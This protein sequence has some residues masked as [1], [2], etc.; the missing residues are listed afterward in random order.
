MTLPVSSQMAGRPRT[1]SGV[2]ISRSPARSVSACS[3]AGASTTRRISSALAAFARATGRAR[4]DVR[5]AIECGEQ[6]VIV[7]REHAERSGAVARVDEL[8]AISGTSVAGKPHDRRSARRRPTARS[9]SRSRRNERDD[10]RSRRRVPRHRAC[11][12][13]FWTAGPGSMPAVRSFGPAMSMQ[14][15]QGRPVSADARLRCAIMRDHSAGPSWAQLMRMQSM[16]AA[17]RSRTSA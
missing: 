4:H 6:D 10:R 5:R 11:G 13:I 1:R 14:T 16:P 8:D 17:T 12:L 3:R 9:R 2:S 15:L 7:P